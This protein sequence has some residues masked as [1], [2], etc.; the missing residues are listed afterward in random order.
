MSTKYEER[1][2]FFDNI[3]LLVKSEQIQM[4]RLL[5]KGGDSFTENSNGVFF[6]V[7]AISDDTFFKMDN[8]MKF[9]LKTRQED[10]DRTKRLEEI[11]L[12]GSTDT[13]N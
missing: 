7:M 3:N 8:F 6:D 10:N 12:E 11:R 5:K 4:F 1:K 13:P 2:I 9:V